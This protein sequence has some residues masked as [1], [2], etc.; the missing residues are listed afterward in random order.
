MAKG[1]AA[2]IV[3]LMGKGKKPGAMDD[4][5]EAPESSEGEDSA[6][7]E[8]AAEEVMAAFKAED[9]KALAEALKSFIDCC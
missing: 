4:E 2:L 8:A 7:R 9:T 3:G 6:A 5:E 1:T